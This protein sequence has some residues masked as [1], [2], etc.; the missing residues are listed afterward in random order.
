MLPPMQVAPHE[1]TVSIAP[2]DIETYLKTYICSALEQ[3]YSKECSPTQAMELLDRAWK[4]QKL[5]WQLRREEASGQ[6]NSSSA[7]QIDPQIVLH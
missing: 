1:T 2:Q 5:L 4:S 3:S 7:F 6:S